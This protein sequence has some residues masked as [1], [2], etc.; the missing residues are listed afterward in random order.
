MAGSLEGVRIL[1]LST[2][3]LG[4]WAGQT[5]GD[6]GAD[7][8]KV[9]TPEGDLMRQLGPRVSDDMG[10]VHLGLNRNKRS[11]VIDLKHARGREVLLRL[12]ATADVVMHNLRPSVA[13]RLGVEYDDIRTAN[14]NIIYCAAYGFRSGGPYQDKPAYDDVIQGASGLAHLQSS[15]SGEP[16]YVPSAAADKITAMAVVSAITAA[17][18]HR[19][20]HGV[21]QSIE[22]PMFETMVSFLMV[23]HLYGHSFQ[24][25]KGTSGYPRVLSPHRRPYATTDGYLCVL[26]YSDANWISLFTIA[27]R[28]DLLADPRF[29][30]A[31][32]RLT[33]ISEAYQILA[34]IL[35]TKSS[36]QWQELLEAANIP[37]MPVNSTDDLLDE[38]Q[39]V[40]GNFWKLM[41]HPTEGSLRMT[42]PP[43]RFSESPSGIW[44]APPHLGEHS[45]E[46]L[47]EAGYAP[48]QIEAL[49]NAGAIGVYQAPTPK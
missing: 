14:A 21:G 45:V 35:S 19:E 2:V 47:D 28:T 39:L 4:P 12:A 43:V 23:E 18:F 48:G 7:V 1:D 32:A 37:V 27:E 20:R 9:E 25:S 3:L 29:Q 38:A 42:D 36:A 31:A 10:S 16:R 11:I 15:I 17:L 13:A 22:V 44:R 40:A 30:T 49:I 24:P 26:P 8:I 5:L 34:E 41:E 6:M 46:V 33:H